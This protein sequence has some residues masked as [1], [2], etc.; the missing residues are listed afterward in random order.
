[1]DR[2]D[3]GPAGRC[4]ADDTHVWELVEQELQSLEEN[5]VVICDDNVD[6]GQAIKEL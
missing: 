1:V 2:V 5:G 6:R 4:G 3:G